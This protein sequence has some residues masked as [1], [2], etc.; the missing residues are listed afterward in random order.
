MS[1]KKSETFEERWNKLYRDF[2]EKYPLGKVFK[3]T[4]EKKAFLKEQDFLLRLSRA[5]S[6]FDRAKQLK[7][8]R[9]ENEEERKKDFDTQFIFFWISFNALYAR[10]PIEYFGKENTKENESDEKKNLKEK[11]FFEKY[12]RNLWKLDK[13]HDQIYKTIENTKEVIDLLENK[14]VTLYF[15]KHYHENPLKRKENHPNWNKSES[16]KG[17]RFTRER[18]D[19]FEMLS[20]IFGRL[21]T[22]RNQVMHGGSAWKVDHLNR[23]QLDDATEIMYKLLSVFIDITLKNPEANWGA[24]FYPRVLGK[25]VIDTDY[26]KID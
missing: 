16:T 21:Y 7:Q 9:K 10:D 8:L 13:K 5:I 18:R 20:I 25:P 17:F 1:R 24:S 3:S 2:M 6:W 26:L 15:W 11:D 12:F 19:T 4:S 14:F 22:L 23:G